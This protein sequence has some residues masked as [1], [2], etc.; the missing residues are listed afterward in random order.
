[1]LDHHVDLNHL[2]FGWRF[3]LLG[4]FLPWKIQL[5]SPRISIKWL[6]VFILLRFTVD[7]MLASSF[8]KI[9]PHT[10]IRIP[11]WM[12]LRI[13]MVAICQIQF[14]TVEVGWHIPT[15][16][17]CGHNN[18]EV[19]LQVRKVAKVCVALY[20]NSNHLHILSC[21]PSFSSCGALTVRNERIVRV[22]S[23]RLML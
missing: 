14:L 21:T 15:P 10:T 18:W 12:S 6:N 2:I 7:V 8:L 11:A 9:T 19:F 1:V 3:V 4:T 16:C 20:W 5:L 23:H 17:N 13:A 22:P